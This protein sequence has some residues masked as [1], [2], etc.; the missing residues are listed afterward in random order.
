MIN[1]VHETKCRTSKFLI[2][3]KERETEN[4]AFEPLFIFLKKRLGLFPK[5]IGQQNYSYYLQT[6]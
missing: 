1:S 3:P 4:T 6:V 2:K 5:V